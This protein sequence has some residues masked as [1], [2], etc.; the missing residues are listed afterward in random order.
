MC[1]MWHGLGMR[2]EGEWRQ[3]V[4]LAWRRSGRG[5]AEPVLAER[6]GGGEWQQIKARVEGGMPHR[7]MHISCEGGVGRRE[8]GPVKVEQRGGVA[9]SGDEA[10]VGARGGGEERAGRGKGGTVERGRLTSSGNE[11]RVGVRGW[12]E[13]VGKGASLLQCKE[14]GGMDDVALT[15]LLSMALLSSL[16]GEEAEKIWGMKRKSE[17]K[18]KSEEEEC[19]QWE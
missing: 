8:Q 1:K 16:S 13:H 14:G 9:S 15:L 6:G 2:K 19:Q 4:V 10:R 5:G 17:E 3:S 12:P 11:V 7:C 18:G